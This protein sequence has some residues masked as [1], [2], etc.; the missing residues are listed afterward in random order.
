[1]SDRPRVLII[2]DDYEIVQAIMVRLTAEG[3]DVYAA[4]GGLQGVASAVTSPPDAILLDIRMP[5]KDGL[6]TLT[7]LREHET[8]RKTPVLILSASMPDRQRALALGAHAFLE[9]PY[10]PT[11]LV[12]ALQSAM[13]HGAGARASERV[14]T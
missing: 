1:M 11:K 14:R 6:T 4:H 10:D 7:E 3:F 13:T 9:K 2:D 5:V 8:T 12:T